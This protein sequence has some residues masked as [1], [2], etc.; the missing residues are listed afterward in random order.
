MN[1]VF[2]KVFKKSIC[3]TGHKG[4]LA[5][6]FRKKYKKK[7]RFYFYPNRIENIN[8]FKKWIS[9]KK[10]NY[11]IHNAAVFRG[12][13]LIKINKKSSI[14]LI[15]FFTKFNKIDHFIFISSA[16]VYGFSRKKFNEN[17]KRKPK[18]VY[19][20]SKKK[21][22]DYIFKNRKKFNFKISV[23]RIFN[24]THQRQKKGHFVPDV[25]NKI[26]KGEKIK[27]INCYRDFIHID[28]VC[29]AIY[30][31]LQKN[32]TGPINI[33]SGKKINLMNITKHISKKVNKEAF[34]DK[35]RALDLFGDNSK[36]KLLGLDKF[37]LVKEIQK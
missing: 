25:I 1:E 9:D 20:T 4:V 24:F 27:N 14:N 29:T 32:F 18:S 17:S 5:S 6:H 2:K 10:F 7:F 35:R 21:V 3:I 12:K 8:H 31:I 13:N 34:I 36:L 22:E 33:C 23:A 19:G 11:F 30:K 15:K 16:H 26:K 37:K 28:D